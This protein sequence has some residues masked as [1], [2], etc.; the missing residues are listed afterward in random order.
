MPG[1][2]HPNCNCA[3]IVLL[4][5]KAGTA[6]TDGF[7]G[8]HYDKLYGEFKKYKNSIYFAPGIKNRYSP[9]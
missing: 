5:I 3:L 9:S 1:E 8:G 6:T 4:C 7:I 2:A